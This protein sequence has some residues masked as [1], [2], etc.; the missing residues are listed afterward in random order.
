MVQC[1]GHYPFC[2]AK[3]VI[4][5]C[6][7]LLQAT[8]EHIYPLL[9]GHS[10]DYPLFV[11][12]CHP[13]TQNFFRRSSVHPRPFHQK[14]WDDRPKASSMF[15]RDMYI[16]MFYQVRSD[17]RSCR[18]RCTMLLQ[19]ESRTYIWLEVYLYL[20]DSVSVYHTCVTQNLWTK[21]SRCHFWFS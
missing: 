3:L 15:I 12:K 16:V 20:T 2:I 11:G 4:C 6:R 1:P 19:S 5:G 7:L 21:T 10:Q 13:Y 9:G 17:T 18:I 14:P 8:L